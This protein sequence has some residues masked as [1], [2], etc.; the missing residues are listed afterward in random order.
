MG[1]PIATCAAMVARAERRVTAAVGGAVARN[2]PGHGLIDNL[3]SH[4]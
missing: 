4:P 1:H 3:S 2:Q